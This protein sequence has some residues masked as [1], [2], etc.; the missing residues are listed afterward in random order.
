MENTPF[1][2]LGFK[3]PDTGLFQT[4]KYFKRKNVLIYIFF[5]CHRLSKQ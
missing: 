4:N 2:R 3:Y 1:K 5:E